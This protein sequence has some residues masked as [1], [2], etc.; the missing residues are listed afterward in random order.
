MAERHGGRVL[1]VV[2]QLEEIFTVC[3]S[4]TERSAFIDLLSHVARPRG[5]AIVVT[6][7]RADYYGRCADYPELRDALQRSPVVV[8]PM[9]ETELREAILFPAQQTGL[10]LETGLVALLLNDLG[11]VESGDSVRE[12]GR[13]PFLAYA[14]QATW[15]Q[16]NGHT[17]TVAGYLTTGGIHHAITRAA[18]RILADLDRDG[19]AA[20]RQT[21]PATRQHRGRR[22]RLA[23]SRRPHRSAAHRHLRRVGQP[24]AG[25]VRRRAPADRQPRLRRDHAR[26]VAARVAPAAAVD[27]L[28]PRRQRDPAGHRRR[29]GRLGGHRVPRHLV[30]LPGHPPRRRAPGHRPGTGAGAHPEHRRRPLPEHLAAPATTGHAPAADGRPRAGRADGHR[31]HRC[32]LRPETTRRRP[33]QRPGRPAEREPTSNVSATSPSSTTSSPRPTRC[34]RAIRRWPPS[35]ISPPTGCFPTTAHAAALLSEPSAVLSKPLGPAATVPSVAFTPDSHTLA[36]A[37]GDDGT[38]QLWD[39]ADPTKVTPLGR[40]RA[41]T[42]KLDAVAVNPQGG[43]LATVGEDDTAAGAGSKTVVRLW[44]ISDLQQSPA[45]VE[46]RRRFHRRRPD[47][48]QPRRQAAGRRHRQR[49][50]VLGRDRS[51]SSPCRA[52]PRARLSDNSDAATVTALAFSPHG[53]LLASSDSAGDRTALERR[54]RPARHRRRSAAEQQQGWQR[55]GVRREWAHALRRGRTVVRH[56]S[57]QSAPARSAAHRRRRRPGPER[58]RPHH[59]DQRRHHGRHQRVGPDRLTDAGARCIR[60]SA[61]VVPP[62]WPWPSARTARSSRA[63]ATA[64]AYGCGRPPIRSK[65]LAFVKAVS[66]DP[67]DAPALSPDGTTLVGNGSDGVD[68]I[69]LTGAAPRKLA[70][71]VALSSAAAFSPDGTLI[72]G[73]DSA[74]TATPRFR[75]WKVVRRHAAPV[76]SGQR[77]RS[78]RCSIR[79][80]TPSSSVAHCGTWTTRPHPK[81]LGKPLAQ[82]RRGRCLQRGRAPARARRGRHNSRSGTSPTRRTRCK[83]SQPVAYPDGSLGGIAFRPDGRVFA[84]IDGEHSAGSGTSYVRLWKIGP[85]GAVTPAAAIRSST[86]TTTTPRSPSRPTATGLSWPPTARSNGGTSPI[87]ITRSRSASR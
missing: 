80:A 36:G 63:A 58:R 16:R 59:G 5:A 39:V 73:T 52:E 78:G 53:D 9:S 72:A 83:D 81:P 46:A 25:R 82:G 28:R 41:N 85:T 1:L 11:T 8:G 86:A 10:E 30:P 57:D 7:L 26:G 14:L 47:R 35:S 74:V 68:L 65:P 75:L 55:A 51:G 62:C 50:P 44:D 76:G 6:G 18:D 87:P 66:A 20:A 42:S 60:C 34:G 61:T 43:T 38:L 27:R 69:S 64:T 2:D 48:V 12:S 37:Y 84:T 21:V 4:E 54:R 45:T 31:H 23:P 56:R 71:G 77:E 40:V 22:R 17:L 32:D 33:G 3:D 79:A 49:H 24:R 19:L 15:R 13:L 29:R 67:L 70:P